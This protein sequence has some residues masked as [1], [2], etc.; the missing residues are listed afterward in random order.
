MK[1]GMKW[2]IVGF[3]TLTVSGVALPVR[4]GFGVVPDD[5]SEQQYGHAQTKCFNRAI[6]G[7]GPLTAE[8]QAKVSALGERD[9]D[10]FYARL[11]V[12]FGTLALNDFKNSSTALTDST[13]VINKR[14]V[15]LN[16]TG[17]E[18]A[19]GYVWNGGMRAELEY[20]V[21]KNIN[22]NAFPVLTGTTIPRQINATIK[23]NTLLVNGYY[24]YTGVPRFRPYL[25]AGIGVSANSA[26]SNL[27]P[28]LGT[29][30]PNTPNTVA[31]AW[32]VGLGARFGIFSRWFIDAKYRYISLGNNIVIQP[33]NGFKLTTLYSMNATSIGL[34]YLF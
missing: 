9:Y 31:F 3:L 23:N 10:R 11:S 15:T 34:I 19:I 20:L 17:L 27:T 13:G 2:A 32:N 29:G 28:A 30:N 21:N 6:N 26:Q 22:Y 14:R 25:T 4:A 33:E 1:Y 18:M 5:Q 7:A 24:E 12:N 16:Q 8:E